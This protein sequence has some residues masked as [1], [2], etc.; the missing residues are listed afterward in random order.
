MKLTTTQQQLASLISGPSG[1]V[2]NKNTIPILGHIKIQAFD[3]LTVTASDMDIE[4]V[5][6]S[7]VDIEQQGECTVPGKLFEGIVKKLPKSA[8]VSLHYDG[9]HLHVSAGRSSFK[10]QTLPA[11]DFPVMASDAYENTATMPAETLHL[12]LQKTKFAMSTEET[13]YCLNGVYLH[14]DDAGDLIAVST[15]GHRLAKMTVSIDANVSGVIIPRKTVLEIIRLLEGVSGDVTLD[16]SET[17]LRLTGDGFQI[18]SK[19]VDGTFPDYTRVI[20]ASHK[21][22]M[23]VDAKEFSAASSSVSAVADA[24]SKAV[25]LAINSDECQLQGRGDVGEAVSAVT[26]TYDGD[27]LDIGFNSAYTA[28]FMAQ[29]EGGAVEMCLGGSMDPALVRFD[30][31]PEF[32]GVLMPCR[33]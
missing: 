9:N 12:M 5:T 22:T 27:P 19:V 23:T 13:R 7:S 31:C 28:D 2:E 16:T 30:E 24:R 25:R 26:V 29:A 6:T 15:D 4:A 21:A 14:N 10:L 18:V 3:A 1:I 32:V 20:P 8:L 33:V 17:K 11:H